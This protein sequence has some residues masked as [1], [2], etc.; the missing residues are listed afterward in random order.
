M[1]GFSRHEKGNCPTNSRLF[2]SKGD[3][4]R[5]SLPDRHGTLGRQQNIADKSSLKRAEKNL[6]KK[7]LP[8]AAKA[9]QE[10]SIYKRFPYI[11][12]KP[13]TILNPAFFNDRKI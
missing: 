9:K 2:S 4:P 6:E 8:K 3:M 5:L 1:K 7:I 10:K 13:K 12:Y 11:N